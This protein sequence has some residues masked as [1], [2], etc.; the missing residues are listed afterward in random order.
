MP[1]QLGQKYG[2]R[3]PEVR[4]AIQALAPEQAARTLLDGKPLGLVVQGE[5]IEIL[6]EEVEVRVQAHAG[7]VVASEGP[8]LAALV[9]DLT[10]ALVKEGLAREFVRRVQD[11]R[12]LAGLDIADRIA[13]YFIA[14]PGLQGA[15][16]AYT[17]YIMAE[18][19]AVVMQEQEIP[20]GA[21]ST[22]DHFDGETVTIGIERSPSK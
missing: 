19:L 21:V 1:R 22:S 7:F 8:Y 5:T 6:P 15:V 20:Q 11:L 17:E 3:F 9:T 4:K 16:T 18:T 2:S 13:L 12:K 14:T 10:P